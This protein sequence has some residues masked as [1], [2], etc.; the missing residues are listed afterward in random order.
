MQHRTDLVIFPPNLRTIVIEGRGYQDKRSSAKN[1]SKVTYS[2]SSGTGSLNSVNQS[3]SSS[4]I[5]HKAAQRKQKHAVCIKH[6]H[7]HV[8]MHSTNQQQVHVHIDWLLTIRWRIG[9]NVGLVINRSWVQV[10]L[11]AIA[12]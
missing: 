7:P 9:W 5:M 3:S 6:T 4:F 11:G 10:L 2:V 8:Q 12:A 1:V